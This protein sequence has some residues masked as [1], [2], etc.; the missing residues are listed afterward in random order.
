M[1]T[2]AFLFGHC[3]GAV[4]HVGI[5]APSGLIWWRS[6]NKKVVSVPVSVK[7]SVDTG[8]VFQLLNDTVRKHPLVMEDPGPSVSIVNFNG[9]T[10][11]YL[12]TLWVADAAKMSKVSADMRLMLLRAKRG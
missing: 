8:Q 9:A 12:L 10:V 11:E 7:R 2:L 4:G 6:R 1:K 3:I 5:V